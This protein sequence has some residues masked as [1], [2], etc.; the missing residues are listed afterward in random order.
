MSVTF[1]TVKTKRRRKALRKSMPKA[2]VMLWRHLK[3]KQLQGFKF[4]RQQSIG[5]YIVDFYCPKAR[6]VIEVDG[7]THLYVKRKE[8][9]L[10][11][12]HFLVER[13]INIIH[14]LNTD[15]YN[16]IQGVIERIIFVLTQY[17]QC[18]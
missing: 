16:N 8:R 3:A 10:A 14:F 11:L 1:N 9:D 6:L 2:E 18:P 15:I 17:K 7:E 5:N 4:R 13:N 12:H